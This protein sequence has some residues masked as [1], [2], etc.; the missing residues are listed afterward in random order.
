MMKSHL[1][2]DF[3][4]NLLLF[5]SPKPTLPEQRINPRHTGTT[6]NRSGRAN[7]CGGGITPPPAV[8][9]SL[10]SLSPDVCAEP[11][12]APRTEPARGEEP[13]FI[14]EPAWAP[15]CFGSTSL[16]GGWWARG[17]PAL[18]WKECGPS[19]TE[20]APSILGASLAAD[21]GRQERTGAKGW[22]GRNL[23]NL[24][25]KRGEL[26]LRRALPAP[27]SS[28]AIPGSRT[29]PPRAAPQLLRSS[30]LHQS[31]G[32]SELQRTCPGRGRLAGM[33]RARLGRLPP[34][35]LAH[36]R[37]RR[38]TR[39]TQGTDRGTGTPPAAPAPAP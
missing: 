4:N 27:L 24:T 20:L 10:A 13:A 2:L 36:A 8:L 6:Q 30:G 37:S 12:W 17:S 23:R 33:R 19:S 5:F 35:C 31:P 15:G 39:R 9:I 38:A 1:K 34:S 11:C 29:P 21:S 26:L 14:S 25:H 18:C 32:T 7:F 28:G 22:G 3:G 16:R